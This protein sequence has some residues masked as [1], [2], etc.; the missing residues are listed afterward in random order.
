MI[1][2]TFN[3]NWNVRMLK[4][5]DV[6]AFGAMAYEL[7]ERRKHRDFN[8]LKPENQH[9]L[10]TLYKIPPMMKMA[11]SRITEVII[12]ILT[13]P[14]ELRPTMEEVLHVFKETYDSM[15]SKKE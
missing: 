1:K 6:Y 8:P 13:T 5:A 9:Y 12:S 4:P 7:I 10:D 2:S 15:I 14:D 3:G 11:K